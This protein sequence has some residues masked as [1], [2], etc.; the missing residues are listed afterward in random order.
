MNTYHRFF[1]FVALV[2]VTGLTFSC[3]GG[4]IT[5]DQSYQQLSPVKPLELPEQIHD[6]LV[7]VLDNVANETDSY[8]NY[9]E[10]YINDKKIEPNWLVTNVQ[11]KYV[12]RLRV[13]P[14]YYD[15]RAKYYAYVGWGEDDYEI[16]SHKLVRV[17]HDKRT[18]VECY[19]TK[20]PNGTPV[21]TPLYFETRTEEYSKTS[22]AK[23]K[24]IHRGRRRR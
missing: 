19:I 23:T 13:R 9:V 3:A 14:G 4:R 21:N 10:L 8:K 2:I 22:T 1:A 18:V 16:K 11:D 17:Q 20:N 15:V 24:A 5:V 12:Y 7:V 6:N